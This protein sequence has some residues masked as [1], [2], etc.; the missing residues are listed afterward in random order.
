MK[1]LPEEK[2][3]IEKKFSRIVT[4]FETLKNEREDYDHFLANPEDAYYK[5]WQ[6]YRCLEF[7]IFFSAKLENYLANNGLALPFDIILEISN[8]SNFQTKAGLAKY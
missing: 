2:A 1:A 8:L 4:A 3:E 5:Y 7:W 6:Y